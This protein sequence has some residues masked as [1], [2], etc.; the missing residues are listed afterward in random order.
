MSPAS[1]SL[2]GVFTPPGDK[3]ISHRV[4]LFSLLAGGSCRVENY[5]PCADC[6]STLGAVTALGGRLERRGQALVLTGAQG[7]LNP[8]AEVDCGNSGTTF[9]LLMGLLAGRPGEY[10]LDGDE[11]LRRRPMERVAA[12]LRL[13]GAGVETTE[14]RPPVTIRGAAL[15]GIDYDLPVASAQLKSSL[16]LAGLQAVGPTTLRE[17]APSRDHSERLLVSCGAAL[18]RGGGWVRVEPS[19]LT[20]PA[21]LRVPGD[22]S[23][24]AFFLCA[25]AITPGS[26]V[27][28]EGVLLNPTRVGFLTVLERMGARLTVNQQGTEPEEW[29]RVEAQY[30]LELTATA[31]AAEEVPLLVDEVPILALV[32]TQAQGVTVFH[33]VEE[34]RIKETDRLA[35]ITSQLGAMGARLWTEGDRLLVQGPTPL[36]VPE[37]L[38]SFGDHRIAMTLRLALGLAGGDCPISDEGC[39]AISYPGFATDLWKL[40]A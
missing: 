21:T 19:S 33:G 3:S 2:S 22:A 25:A 4:G 30:S 9:R 27:A 10:R 34:L 29:G 14:G 17:P 6:Q 8:R 13:M 1:R 32:A 38:E 23:S 37:R 26:R 15:R 31:I 12:P 39:A 16:L 7:R 35:A 18:T 28:A 36:T 24:A 11:S 5:S 20:L 40:S